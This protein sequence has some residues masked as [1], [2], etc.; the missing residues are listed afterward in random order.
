MKAAS[1]SPGSGG[2]G[3]GLSLEQPLLG[4]H[5]TVSR[6]QTGLRDCLASEMSR[7]FCFLAVGGAHEAG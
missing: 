2:E 1:A 5:F 3:G 4:V 7:V 6:I